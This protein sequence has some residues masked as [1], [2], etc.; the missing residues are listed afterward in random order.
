MTEQELIA[1]KIKV[2]KKY[3]NNFSYQKISKRLLNDEG[4]FKANVIA[5]KLGIP[6][7]KFYIFHSKFCTRIEYNNRF[8]YKKL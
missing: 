2:L 8:Y 7:K 3:L 4:Y 5:K 6:E 1:E